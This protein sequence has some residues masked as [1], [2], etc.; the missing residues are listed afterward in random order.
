M[1]LTLANYKTNSKT[2]PQDG[3]RMFFMAILDKSG[4]NKKQV[5]GE[6]KLAL[7]RQV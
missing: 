1:K 3:K 5:D 7:V 4:N 6:N 2:P